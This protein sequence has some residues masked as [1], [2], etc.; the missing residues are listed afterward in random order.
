M[1]LGIKL[2]IGL[3]DI[4]LIYLICLSL[5]IYFTPAGLHYLV[6]LYSGLGV[7]I[8]NTI[9]LIILIKNGRRSVINY[10]PYLT[11]PLTIFSALFSI[12]SSLFGIG[13]STLSLLLIVFTS[14]SFW[15]P[16]NLGSTMIDRTIKYFSIDLE[17][18][19]WAD[20]KK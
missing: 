12:E 17:A 11:V 10:I 1:K 14:Y 5:Y 16:N 2:I 4:G 18:K 13:L 19:G 8:L 6:V 3:I 20:K 9:R 15:I 7:I